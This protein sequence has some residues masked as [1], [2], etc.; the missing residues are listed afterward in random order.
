VPS[1]A[2]ASRTYLGGDPVLP[3]SSPREPIR[4]RRFLKKFILTVLFAGFVGYAFV[5]N[6]SELESVSIEVADVVNQIGAASRAQGG[7]NATTN[8][9]YRGQFLKAGD[10][11]VSAHG[12]ATLRLSRDG[13]LALR[14]RLGTI[15]WKAK[16]SG[17]K[18]RLVLELFGDLSLRIGSEQARVWHSGTDGQPV[19]KLVLEDDCSLV[20]Y[21]PFDIKVWAKGKAYA[22]CGAPATS[23]T[24][25]TTS[26]SEDIL[27]TTSPAP[28]PEAEISAGTAE[29]ML[30]ALREWLVNVATL[31]DITAMSTLQ[32][33]FERDGTKEVV[34]TLA[35]LVSG[36]NRG[37][38]TCAKEGSNCRCPSREIRFGAPP[39]KWTLK[40][41]R[42]T[43]GC[44]AGEFGGKDPAHGVVKECQCYWKS[45]HDTS[46]ADLVS[47]GRPSDQKTE[48]WSWQPASSGERAPNLPPTAAS[49]D[50]PRTAWRP[51][52]SLLQWL[53]TVDR[54]QLRAVAKV[55]KWLVKTRNTAEIAVLINQ[56]AGKKA[57]DAQRPCPDGQPVHLDRC[58][59]YGE[60]RCIRGCSRDS[61]EGFRHSKPKRKLCAGGVGQELVWS[62]DH[63]VTGPLAT[64]HAH[65]V[66][67]S[68]INSSIHSL[69]SSSYFR[70]ML[71]VYLDCEF[72]P[73]YLRWVSNESGWLQEAYV[74]YVHGKK[75]SKYEWQATNLVRSVDLFSNRPVVVVA[76]G[77]TFVPPLAWHTMPN[78]IVYR[79]QPALPGVSFNFNK[80]RA[81]VSTR[82]IVG[83]ELDT[84]Q[85]IAPGMDM[86]FKST[87]REITEKYPWPMMPTHW[88]SRDTSHE[89]EP[90]HGYR[91]RAWGGE[92]TMR[93]GH[94]HPTWSYWALPFLGDLLNER[95]VAALR[96][97]PEGRSVN[98]W[99]LSSLSGRGMMGLIKDKA[100]VRREA[101][102]K[103]FM[104]ED[105]DMLNVAL[106]R[107]QAPKHW[108]KFDLEPRLYLGPI[109]EKKIYWDNKWYPEGLPIVFT[110]MHNTKE[111]EETNW[112][113]TMLA[114]CHEFRRHAKSHKKGLLSSLWS[115]FQGSSS[116][117]S[118]NYHG[119]WVGS[120]MEVELRATP[121]K[122]L[123]EM[124]RCFDPR[125]ESPFYWNGKWF[126]NGSSVRYTPK[127]GRSCTMP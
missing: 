89:H 16:S 105:E 35:T 94:A 88:M 46:V 20:L 79:M 123:I 32:Q 40:K 57:R 97:A 38:N 1:M 43:T 37:W 102:Y 110:S 67:E 109:L 26:T 66:A 5:S 115:N 124:C 72:L 52:Q 39:N 68:V 114:R 96:V 90:Y 4:R 9:L 82:V 64:S 27:T 100:R 60:H 95:F 111:F 55:W 61:V 104:M 119:C 76:F 92:R 74:T 12:N 112:L 33:W 84:D 29:L 59:G 17:P 56:A 93:W 14:S 44:S 24:T 101:S 91:F 18:A 103:P 23:T 98:A 8:T 125:L 58:A 87:A 10:K 86:F 127:K 65:H 41:G 54:D 69:C 47:L 28:T 2:G 107:D 25:M 117:R 118:F 85:L 13:Q 62:C 49:A 70:H 7:G 50:P 34:G 116:S 71:D 73:G 21:N 80:I 81:M 15:L 22:D 126:Q 75:D 83:I 77:D 99:K 45:E 63:S 120:N 121:A 53:E 51:L 78:V 122:Y 31:Q 3:S 106:W 113:L 42:T 30:K 108:C 48:H 11:L 19:E 6:W 36:S